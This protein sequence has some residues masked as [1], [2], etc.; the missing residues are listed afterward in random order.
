MGGIGQ[1]K[2]GVPTQGALANVSAGGPIH[3]ELWA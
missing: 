2:G 3:D 1:G